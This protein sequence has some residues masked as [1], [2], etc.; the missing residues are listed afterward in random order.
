MCTCIPIG[1]LKVW[2]FVAALTN[3]GIGIGFIILGDI[4]KGFDGDIL[5]IIPDPDSI[6]DII[7]L[8]NLVCIIV[9]AFVI[10][11]GL[12]TIVAGLK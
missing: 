1:F 2:V 10:F 7:K 11:L 12:V 3:F 4:I 8:I 9:G 5:A 6:R